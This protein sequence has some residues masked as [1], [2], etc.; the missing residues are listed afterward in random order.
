MFNTVILLVVA[1]L[2]RQS[3]FY[4]LLF[5]LSGARHRPPVPLRNYARAIPFWNFLIIYE[6]SVYANDYAMICGI[7]EAP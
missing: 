6:I 5:T 1:H 2:Y 7:G 3:N 4:P